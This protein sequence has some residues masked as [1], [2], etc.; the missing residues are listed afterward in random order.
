LCL[1]AIVSEFPIICQNRRIRYTPKNSE[2][3][4]GYTYG[5][6]I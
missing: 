1:F 5:S 4:D 2:D 6:S 3:P